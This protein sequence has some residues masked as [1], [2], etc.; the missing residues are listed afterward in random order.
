MQIQTHLAWGGSG[1]SALPISPWK[2][3]APGSWPR[4]EQEVSSFQQ[5]PVHPR[6]SLVFRQQPHPISP[7]LLL[8]M[9][10]FC[11]INS[12]L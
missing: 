8:F 12:Y 9:S 2:C 11:E 7:L 1:E 5:F 6:N 10:T 4:F 3:N